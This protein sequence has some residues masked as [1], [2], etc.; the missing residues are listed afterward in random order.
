[1]LIDDVTAYAAPTARGDDQWGVSSQISVDFHSPIRADAKQLRCTAQVDHRADGWGFSSG[2][3]VADSGELTATIG[4]RVKFF[5]VDVSPH[6]SPG[7]PADT[8][9]WLTSLD[10]HLELTRRDGTRSEFLLHPDPGMRNVLGTLHGGVSLAFSELAA[11]RACEAAGVSAAGPL[12]TS[13]V[14]MS[15]LRP[16]DP[17]DDFSVAVDLIHVSRSVVIAEVRI[18]NADGRAATF[19]LVTLHRGGAA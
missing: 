8:A 3:V 7:L 5:P 15:Y 1:M 9:S 17:G 14:R 12:R 19:G 4:Q 18:L 13:S 16:G 11:R 10:S 2:R 6:R